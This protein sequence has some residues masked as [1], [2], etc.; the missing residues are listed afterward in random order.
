MW[1]LGDSE[2]LDDRVFNTRRNAE[3]AA[4]EQAFIL[5]NDK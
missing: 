4:I 3:M 2:F 1:S 5:L